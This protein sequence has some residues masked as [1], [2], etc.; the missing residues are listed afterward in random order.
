MRDTRQD[1]IQFWF[2]ETEPHQWFDK[3]DEFDALI[4]ARF[5][6]N[7]E[8]ACEG[9]C[10]HWQNEADGALALCIVLDQFPRNMFRGDTQSFA[11]DE[12]ALFTAKNAVSKGFDKILKPL[13]RGFLYMPFMHSENIND[14]KKSVAFF[15]T[16]IDDNPMGYDY[17]LKHLDVIQKFGRFPH[18]NV[19][20]GRENTPQEQ[21]YLALPDAGF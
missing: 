7:Y 11:S 17:A 8:M 1:I 2:S 6:M 20:L 21:E 15:K 14:Q 10:D 4:R 9:L 13:K 5:L 12:K 18:R 16:M 3:N 19:V